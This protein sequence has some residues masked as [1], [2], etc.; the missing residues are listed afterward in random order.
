[1]DLSDFI[2]NLK[3]IDSNDGLKFLVIRNHEELP[4]KKTGKDIDIIVKPLDL[5]KW[6]SKVKFFCEKN[7]LE[8]ITI[9]STH[10]CLSTKVLGISNC[11]NYELYLDF[12]YEFNWRGVEFYPINEFVDSS[13]LHNEFIYTSK[14]QF[15]GWYITFCHSFLYGGFVNQ[16]YIENYIFHINMN[17]DSFKNEFLRIFTENEVEFLFIS[18]TEGNEISKNEA[19]IIRIKVIF[20]NLIKK[21]YKNSVSLIKTF[22]NG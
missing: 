3:K 18:I 12:N 11:H 15:T 21:P 19:N 17:Y 5:Q 2:C 1:M 13:I 14:N 4:V 20:R 22:F 10:Y 8:F 9:K 7:N 6:L 16:K